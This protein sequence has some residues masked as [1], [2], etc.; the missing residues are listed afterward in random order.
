LR[1]SALVLA[2]IAGL[3]AVISTVGLAAGEDPPPAGAV[4]SLDQLRGSAS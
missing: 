2:F 1:R 4:T 3:V